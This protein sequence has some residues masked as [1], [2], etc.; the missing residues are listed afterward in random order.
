M[1]LK[2]GKGK[3]GTPWK[4][5]LKG[6]VASL[7]KIKRVRREYREVKRGSDRFGK[8]QGTGGGLHEERRRMGRKS[9]AGTCRSIWGTIT[10][11]T[12]K[13]KKT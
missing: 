3:S 5:S 12:G 10:K 11:E 1:R 13:K 8:I 9:R 2:K 7:E 4:R 6:G